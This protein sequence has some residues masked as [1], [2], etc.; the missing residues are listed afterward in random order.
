MAGE[1]YWKIL[2]VMVITSE[3]IVCV[4][5]EKKYKTIIIN[6][7]MEHLDASPHA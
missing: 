7:P 4:Y 6:I 2:F 5:H 1:K 3:N